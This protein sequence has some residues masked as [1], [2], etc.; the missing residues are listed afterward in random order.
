MFG[1]TSCKICS[2]DSPS[3]W[4]INLGQINNL[5]TPHMNVSLTVPKKCLLNFKGIHYLGGRFVPKEIIDK[6]GL[7]IPNYQGIDQFQKI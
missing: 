4:D 2:V 6:Y 7:T 5:F 1:E 3:G